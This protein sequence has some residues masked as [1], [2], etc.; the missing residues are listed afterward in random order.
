MSV[1]LLVIT[2]DGIGPSLL[3][4]TSL[5][6][7]GCP[8]EAKL[9]MASKDSNP[10]ELRKQAEEFI[11]L[12][13]TGDGVLILTDLYGSTPSNIAIGLSE[14]HNTR[15]ISGVNLSMLIRVLNYP[16]LALDELAEK[17]M[18]GGQDGI[19]EVI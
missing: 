11:D 9:L 2:H 5:M 8:L 13:D 12:L 1:G 17:A 10:D 14:H 18:S 15:A 19:Q 6:L 3:G 4:T 16:E 7:G